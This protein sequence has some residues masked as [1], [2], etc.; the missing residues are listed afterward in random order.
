MTYLYQYPR[1]AVAPAPKWST[2]NLDAEGRLRDDA[3]RLNTD[4]AVAY[5]RP[6]RQML[7]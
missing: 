2:V 5:L 4:V 3:D 7:D 6:A 1:T